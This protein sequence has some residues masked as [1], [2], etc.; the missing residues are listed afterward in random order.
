MLPEPGGQ[1]TACTKLEDSAGARISICDSEG[2]KQGYRKG[3]YIH[4]GCRQVADMTRALADN[5][6]GGKK[7][8]RASGYIEEWKKTVDGWEKA[9][10]WIEISKLTW[11]RH[12]LGWELKLGAI[13]P[14][15][16]T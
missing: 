16:Q 6:P 12:G 10:A 1:T 9:K 15:Y 3:G 11:A 5:C 8:Q 4:I 13:E 14:C 7:D 2:D